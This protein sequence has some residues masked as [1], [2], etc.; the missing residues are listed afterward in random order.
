MATVLAPDETGRARVQT[1]EALLSFVRAVPRESGL[2]VDT[3]TAGLGWDDEVRLVQLGTSEAGFAVDVTSAEG[4]EL[5]RQVLDIYSGPLIFHNAGFDIRALQRIGLDP[6]LL[7]PRAIDTYVI[8]HVWDAG[9]LN[10]GLDALNRLLLDDDTSGYKK[11]FR[12]FMRKKKWTWANVPKL[13][14]TPYGV[15]D[16]CATHAIYHILTDKLTAEEW[17]VVYQEMD[18]AWA[19]WHV[20]QHGMRLD[21]EYAHSLRDRWTTYLQHSREHFKTEWEVENPNS[22]RQIATALIDHGWEPSVKT[23]SGEWKLDKKMLKELAPRFDLVQH[24]L[25]H[26][27]VTKWLAAYVENCL[28]A[29]DARGYVHASYNSLGARTGRM[30]CS[31][32]P[33]QQLPKGGGG[34]VRR[35]FVAS[36][37]NVIASCD[38]SAIEFRL[39]GALSGEERIMEVYRHNGD[40]YQQIA[41][42][43]GIARPEAKVLLLATLY[44]AG[45]T[46][47]AASLGWSISVAR[48][49]VRNFWRAYPVLDG[50][51]RHLVDEANRGVVVRSAKWG[52][53]LAPHAGYAAPNAVIQGTAAEVM[54]DGIT[55]LWQA[56]LLKHVCAVVHDEVVLDVPEAEAADIA[57]SVALVLRD[58]TFDLPLVAEAEVYGTSWGDGYAA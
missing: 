1:D 4:V 19:M 37:G 5:V 55:R 36:E 42:E 25:E 53:R 20:E 30:S 13:L 39:A 57:A 48:R 17:N 7:W 11:S 51:N 33:L 22:N 41:D 3:E 44:G 28:A 29:V 23:P 2:A 15:K 54:K 31:N 24:L 21:I 34:E 6:E 12:D 52:R 10:K 14:L 46:K 40:W 32:P 27:R 45:P 50:W 56:D 38:Y 16:T 35:L 58:D 18:V 8:A 43:V 9:L 49:H 26:K 47:I